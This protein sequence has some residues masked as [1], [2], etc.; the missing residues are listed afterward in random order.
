MRLNSLFREEIYS[1]RSALVIAFSIWFLSLGVEIW[2]GYISTGSALFVRNVQ[3]CVIGIM[4]VLL[5][6]PLFKDFTESKHFP[7]SGATLGTSTL[8]TGLHI[9]LI[10]TLPLVGEG[11][12][13]APWTFL[14]PAQLLY[15]TYF[16]TYGLYGIVLFK[17]S[18]DEAHACTLAATKLAERARLDALRYQVAPH[19][20]F[21][22]LAA[23]SSL[24]SDARTGEAKD[25]LIRLSEFYRGRVMEGPSDFVSLEEEVDSQRNYLEIERIRLGHRLEA[26]IRVP[27]ALKA[28]R[29]PRLIL[30]PLVE[31]AIK[32][33]AAVS[34]EPCQIEVEAFFH[35]DGLEIVITNDLPPSTFG[36][37]AGTGTGLENVKR[38]IAAIY[39]GRG[40]V[41]VRRCDRRYA[42]H[43]IIPEMSC[44]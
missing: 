18:M 37:A 26:S 39:S 42:V 5:T 44:E 32:H 8:A 17:R 38:R 14:W 15:L 33:G 31:N 28:H 25:L 24:I 30:Q 16:I 1:D 2:E 23:C 20:L 34:T 7:T 9:L 13:D 41:S 12:N 35:A 11:P 22:A 19:F 4:V 6:L 27:E 3:E 21:N 29:V 43:M 40:S 36:K 10:T